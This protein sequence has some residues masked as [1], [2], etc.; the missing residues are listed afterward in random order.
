MLY[1]AHIS[2][3]QER[4]TQ[5]KEDIEKQRKILSKKKPTVAGAKTP[6]S[7]A[8]NNDGFLRPMDKP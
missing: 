3:H 7:S 8:A 1:S 6:K 5:G 4:I 2:R